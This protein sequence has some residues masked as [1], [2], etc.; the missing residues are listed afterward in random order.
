VGFSACNGLF[1]IDVPP[2]KTSSS[3]DGQGGVDETG[4]AG[5]G[6]DFNGTGGIS[7]MGEA[8]AVES[9]GTA[10]DVSAQAARGGSSAGRDSG[11]AGRSASGPSSGGSS[12]GGA[13]G[14]AGG[15][16]TPFPGFGSPCSREGELACE[17]PKSPHTLICEDGVWSSGR[18]CKEG[19]YCDRRSGACS[20]AYPGCEGAR[21]G[22]EI[23][24]DSSDPI[25]PNDHYTLLACGP[26]LVTADVTTCIFGCDTSNDV[27]YKPSGSLLVVER[28]PAANAVGSFWPGPS[29]PVCFAPSA[30]QNWRDVVQDEVERTW[31][32][33]AGIHFDGWDDCAA[34][35]S[36]VKVD[37][38][39]NDDFCEGELGGSDR[40]GYPGPEGSVNISLCLGYED[41]DGLDHHTSEPLLR[42]VTRHEFGHALGFDDAAPHAIA[43][44]FMAPGLDANYL[45]SYTFDYP[46]IWPLQRAY[47]FKPSGSIVDP[48]GRC[49]TASGGTPAFVTCDGSP[50]QAFHFVNEQLWDEGTNQC[51]RADP[52]DGTVTFVACTPAGSTPDPAQTWLP[53]Q[54]LMHPDGHT[55]VFDNDFV[56]TD[57]CADG[58]GSP[59]WNMDLIDGG[60]RFRFWKTD[61]HDATIDRCIALTYADPSDA[62]GAGLDLID[63]EQCASTAPGCDFEF[64]DAE[65]IANAGICLMADGEG[66][67]PTPFSPPAEYSGLDHGPC[68]LQQRS[69]WSLELRF[70]GGANQVLAER[71]DR[72]E[73][74][75]VPVDTSA[76]RPLITSDS[77]D[78]YPRGAR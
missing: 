49:L 25:H 30:P 7:T 46:D 61:K 72:P 73:L 62:K 19:Y 32:R 75:A 12:G 70:V 38:R 50:E 53:A 63:C 67:P 22:D 66:S 14:N 31:G 18:E 37:F 2:V 40:I 41:G 36:G 26:D 34:D 8:G 1:G 45:D 43:W 60:R 56:A 13:N 74:V 15:S 11:R 20:V 47:G 9:G 42:L 52:T 10:G 71:D 4:M 28:P 55:C 59:L 51:L 27:C 54:V 44:E 58:F 21:P 57:L 68:S 3:D 24:G 29:V 64:T 16:A 6:G 76:P 78:Y 23:C 33:Y 48:N 35:A 17:D 5:G 77:F 65:Q 39:A 69:A